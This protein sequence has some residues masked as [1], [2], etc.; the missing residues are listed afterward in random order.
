MGLILKVLF[1]TLLSSQCFAVLILEPPDDIGGDIVHAQIVKQIACFNNT[2][3]CK[4]YY[5]DDEWTDDQT[6][7]VTD[8]AKAH[9]VIN[10]SFGFQ[11]P[12]DPSRLSNESPTPNQ[13]NAKKK[14]LSYDELVKNHF[15][16][17]D[18]IHSVFQNSPESLFVIAAGNGFNIKGIQSKGVPLIK[19]NNIFP[20][21]LS[22]D[23]LIK[24]TSL[25]T[26]K[27]DLNKL[28]DYSI[29]KYANY[30]LEL[31]DLAA[32][33]ET[34]SEN[35]RGTSFSAPLVCRLADKASVRGLNS[36]IIKEMLYK[37]SYVQSLDEAIELTEDYI[38]DKK[39]S[40]IYKI[41]NEK[42]RKKRD[43]MLRTK[44]SIMFVKSGGPLV[45]SLFNECL[46]IFVHSNVSVEEACLQAHK[47][48]LNIDDLRA[49]KLKKFWKLR[50]I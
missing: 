9:K 32:P 29:A 40:L 12:D 20:A 49:L 42:N 18:S 38:N 43:H 28:E 16:R 7:E 25:S 22:Y 21:T 36:E 45:E 11:R 44:T 26:D 10:M 8:L 4:L 46:K 23:N 1:L 24:V 17:I 39:K 33:V 37:S 30:S 13:S 50:K 19:S 35:L 27:I 5:I 31:V 3:N 2:R 6:K 41:Q 14:K 34:L 47:S 15:S 48:A